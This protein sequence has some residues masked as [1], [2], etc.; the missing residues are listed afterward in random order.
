MDIMTD[1]DNFITS[2]TTEGE[3]ID[4]VKQVSIRSNKKLSP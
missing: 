4:F 2:D 1:L 3:I